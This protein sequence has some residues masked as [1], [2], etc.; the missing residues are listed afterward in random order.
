MK[1]ENF[2]RWS[3]NDLCPIKSYI[4]VKKQSETSQKYER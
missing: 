1:R 3:L 4:R 2:S